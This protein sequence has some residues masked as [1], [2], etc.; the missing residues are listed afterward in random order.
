MTNGGPPWDQVRAAQHGD[1]DAFGRLYTHYRAEV[2]RYALYRTRD[3]WWAE[4]VTSET[5]L[6][7]LRR[8]DTLTYEGSGVGA[9][10]ITITRNILADHFKSARHQR[11]LSVWD[12]SDR[13]DTASV[14]E[15][16]ALQRE[17]THELGAAINRL[18]SSQQRECVHHRFESGRSIRDTATLMGRSEGAVKAL[19]HRAVVALR[20]M[21]TPKEAEPNDQPGSEDP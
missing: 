15:L 5:F 1:R 10:L 7:A 12:T 18:G 13:P 2:Y 11:E 3:V 21:L 8:I 20:A 17:T 6:R 4:D 14:P 16:I 9:W 19:T